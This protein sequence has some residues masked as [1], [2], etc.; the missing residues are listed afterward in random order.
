MQKIVTSL[1]GAFVVATST[2]AAKPDSLNSAKTKYPYSLIGE[3]FGILNEADLAANTCDIYPQPFSL[4]SDSLYWRCFE[5]KTVTFSCDSNGA[6]DPNEGLMGLIVLNV[7]SKD[8]RHEY[9]ARRPWPIADCRAFG[10]TFAAAIEGTRH[11][12]ISGSSPSKSAP[13]R[14]TQ[15]T[16]WIFEKYKTSK[17]C[18]SYFEG[19]CGLLAFQRNHGCIVTQTKASESK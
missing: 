11:I 5:S 8:G 16:T 17:Y 18:G 13:P 9:I 1:I 15:I 12:C 3:D 10:R 6:A 4:G 2:L 14:G 19:R 7:N